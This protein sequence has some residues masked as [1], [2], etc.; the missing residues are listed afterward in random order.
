VNR[1]RIRARKAAN[2][3]GILA[4][5]KEYRDAHK[6]EMRQYG[7]VWREKN[8]EIIAVKRAACR[9]LNKEKAN[10]TRA[11]WRAARRAAGIHVKRSNAS[12]ARRRKKR[13]NFLRRATPAWLTAEQKQQIVDL[14]LL[15]GRIGVSNVDHIVPLCSS[16]VC[17]LHVP[18]NLR[19]ITDAENVDK[20]NGQHE[21]NYGYT[22]EVAIAAYEAWQ[23]GTAK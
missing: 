7:F 15:S 4:K 21:P 3:Q 9:A 10:A 14:Y 13:T 22:V 12:T 23:R 11:K 20:S 2:R 1:E 8:R 19:V 5:Q 16:E 17:G 6:E 18:W